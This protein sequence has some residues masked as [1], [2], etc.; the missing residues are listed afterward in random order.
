[1]KKAY[2]KI[3]W[4]PDYPIPVGRVFVD[5]W[6][7]KDLYLHRTLDNGWRVSHSSGMSIC[8]VDSFAH[9]KAVIAHLYHLLSDWSE[10]HTKSGSPE[11]AEVRKFVC[12]PNNC[13][14]PGEE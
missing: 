9:G 1:M 10:A 12:W 13:K 11:Y 8:D 14:L 2:F 6:R 4:N 5:A 3:H 7:E